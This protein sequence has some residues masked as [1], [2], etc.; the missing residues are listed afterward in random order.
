MSRKV[1]IGALGL[2]RDIQESSCT[3]L[4]FFTQHHYNRGLRPSQTLRQG[5]TQ[6]KLVKCSLLTA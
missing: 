4:R 5:S 1:S 3:S 2:C 6:A